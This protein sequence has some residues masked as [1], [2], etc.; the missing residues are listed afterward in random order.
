MSKGIKFKDNIYLD[1][2]GITHNRQ[3]LKDKLDDVDNNILNRLNWQDIT[4]TGTAT[5][6]TITT[7]IGGANVDL[8]NFKLLHI[9][10]RAIANSAHRQ[11]MVMVFPT[12][13]NYLLTQYGNVVHY[14][15]M[16]SIAS[17]SFGLSITPSSGSNAIQL[18]AIRGII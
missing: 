7:Q 5:G 3:L 9:R 1:S 18:E 14:I 15:T 6:G 12:S 4:W 17:G 11:N 2:T 10:F 13:N 8:R 16:A